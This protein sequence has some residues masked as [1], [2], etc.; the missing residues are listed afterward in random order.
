MM[1]QEGSLQSKF[2]RSP[3]SKDYLA[4]IM[5]FAGK[6]SKYRTEKQKQNQKL[7]N[8]S[9]DE[10]R[11]FRVPVDV[12]KDNV[13]LLRQTKEL[14]KVR[15]LMAVG[16]DLDAK[17]VKVNWLQYLTMIK[18]LYKRTKDREKQKHFIVRLF[19]P[20]ETGYVK[21]EEFERI[22]KVIF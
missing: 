6:I 14:A 10:I 8:L 4:E 1:K 7:S 19:D 5:P 21:G 3:E 15:I 2:E 17:D 9:Q 20:H 13:R 18:M 11:D 22:L 16:V 12:F